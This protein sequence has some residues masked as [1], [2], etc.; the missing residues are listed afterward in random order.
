MI[1]SR[2]TYTTVGAPEIDDN[3]LLAHL[4][5]PPDNDRE[6]YLRLALKPKYSDDQRELPNSIRRLKINQLR[7]FYAPVLQTHRRALIEISSQIFE[8]YIPRNPLTAEGQRFLH[9]GPTASSVKPTISFIAGHSGMGKSTL[10]DRIAAHLGPQVIQHEQFRT[11]VFPESQLIWLRRNVPEHCTVRTLC[12]S[13]GDYVDSVLG[14]DLYRGIFSSFRGKG[15]DR[16]LYISQ[17]RKII[18]NHHVGA[19]ILDEFQNLSLMGVGAD[20]IIAFLVAL[21]DELGIPI[22]IVGTYKSLRLLEKDLSTARR[23]VEGGYFDLERPT[24]AAD[25]N[26][27]ELCQIAW[28]YQWTRESIDLSDAITEALYDVSQ[29]ITGIMLT[30]L[31]SAQLAAIECGVERVD[32]DLILKVFKERMQPLHPAVRALQS[33]SHTLIEKFDDIYKSSY[34][35]TDRIIDSPNINTLTA[36]HLTSRGKASPSKPNEKTLSPEQIKSMVLENS[37]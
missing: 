27:Q 14:V 6:A 21:R 36:E 26:W 9:G 5:L 16:N 25:S 22:V 17:I 32:A 15:G 7:K 1:S 12:A 10:I 31:I 37:E 4:Q 13:F 29:G 24:S 3:P 20:K 28:K 18:S 2:P 33:G 34:P 35:S 11:T 23:L 30:S 19:L 8:G